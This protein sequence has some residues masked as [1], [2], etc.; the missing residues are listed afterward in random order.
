MNNQTDQK[1]L[2]DYAEC[3]SEAAFA[4][5]VQRHIDLVYSAA[6]RMVRDT[7]LA[8]DVAQG[9]FVAFAQN[10]R[11]LTGRPVISGWLH[12]TT[13]NLAANAVRS[14][15]RRRA[16]EQ[17]AAAM[18]ESLANDPDA[19]W[20]HIAPVLDAALGELNEADRDALL[21]R[22]FERKSAREMAQTLGTSEDAAQKR[23][24]R[25][26][27]RLREFLV[28]RGVTVGAGGLA[29]VI[30][31][32]AVHAAPAGLALTISSSAALA[33]TSIATTTVTLTKAIAMTTLQ[34]TIVATIIVAVVGAGIY[35]A[36]EASRLRAQVRGLTQQQ[37]Q[38]MT[39]SNQVKQLQLERDRATNQL[40]TLAVENAALKK[41]PNEV[42]KLRGEVGKLRQ[43]N[44]TM[45]SS[46]ALSKL[47]ANPEAVKMIRD[48]QKAGMSMIYKGFAEKAKLTPDQTEKINDLLADHIMQ[49]ISNVT[50]VLHDKPT[51]YQMTQTFAAQE[52]ALEDKVQALVGPDGLAQYQDYTKNL[53]S[54]LSTQQF[55]NSLTGTD[56]EKLQKSQQFSQAMQQAT[57]SALA[58]A[59]LPADYQAVPILNF[60]NIASEQQADASLKLLDDIYQRVATSGSSFLSPE[61]LA[62]FQEFRTKAIDNNHTALTVNRTLMAPIS[63]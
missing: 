12:R 45:G 15:V 11:Q 57:A 59:G 1:L 47:T 62:K 3:R 31:V 2:Y 28:K 46:S 36:R 22:Y 27:E 41:N 32:H 53:L 55:T 39:L 18:N 10:A 58:G 33:G 51:T 63:Q 19:S 14:D 9:V 4:E 40:A 17:E 54:T 50:A 5:L 6:L 56:A 61:E 38:Q 34:K 23:V 42:L 44:A 7:H 49:N 48:Q 29:I 30:S 16:R 24:N 60:A 43:E 20:E 35:Q 52:A 26:V 21:L 25:A 8:E 13:Q 37:E